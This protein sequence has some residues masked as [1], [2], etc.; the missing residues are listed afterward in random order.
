MIW[1]QAFKHYSEHAFS[2]TEVR[3][4]GA[5]L[6]FVNVLC[7][8]TR[9]DLES[10]FT[11]VFQIIEDNPLGSLCRGILVLNTYNVG[12]YFLILTCGLLSFLC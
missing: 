11:C 3:F 5:C 2:E 10:D 1:K 8:F 9:G 7:I 6:L 12:M 4:N